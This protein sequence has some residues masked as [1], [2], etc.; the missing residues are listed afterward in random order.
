MTIVDP[1]LD[2][3]ADEITRDCVVAVAAVRAAREP[4]P[5]QQQWVPI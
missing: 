1:V 5:A 2:Q 3:L 4:R